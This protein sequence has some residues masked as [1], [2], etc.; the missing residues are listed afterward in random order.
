MESKLLQIL[1]SVYINIMYGKIANSIHKHFME[2]EF[3]S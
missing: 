3:F 1:K 2:M